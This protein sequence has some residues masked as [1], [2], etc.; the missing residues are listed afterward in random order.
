VTAGAIVGALGA[1]LVMLVSLGVINLSPE[2]QTNILAFAAAVLP[3]VGAL[4]ARRFVTPV[5]GG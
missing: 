5:K 3:L 4:I 2:Q 1:G